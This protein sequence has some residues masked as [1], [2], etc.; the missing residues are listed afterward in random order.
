MSGLGS[1]TQQAVMSDSDK[2]LWW[3]VHKKS[4]DKFNTGNGKF[5]PLTFFTIVFHIVGN[6]IFVHTDN[7]VVADG[8]PV[9][10][11]PKVVDNGLC[12]IKGFL[13]VGNPVLVITKIQEFLEIIAVAVFYAASVKLK[14][15]LIPKCFK[16]IQI[17]ALKQLGH[18]SYRKKEF[19]AFIT[20]LIIG[21]QTTTKENDM[22]M[23]M[24]VH[25]RTPGM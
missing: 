18:N 1:G 19:F 17:F 21:S 25:F 8:N 23:G 3:N 12:T 6:S 5:R 4:A 14:L 9:G 7:A 16:N 22:D 2:T 11:F 24:I 15:I 20:P 13:A 10:I